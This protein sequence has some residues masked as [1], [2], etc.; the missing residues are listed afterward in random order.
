MDTFKYLDHFKGTNGTLQALSMGL[1]DS[2]P[3]CIKCMLKDRVST[4]KNFESADGFCFKCLRCKRRFSIRQGSFFSRSN[5]S[6]YQIMCLVTLFANRISMTETS[7]RLNIS[8]K[9]V[10]EWFDFFRRV[11]VVSRDPEGSTLETP[12]VRVEIDES[13]NQEPRTFFVPLVTRD[14]NSAHASS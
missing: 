8:A 3:T 14:I 1:L 12:G 9:T 2:S 6:I 4:Q 10:I 5:L 13:V 11:C 7:V